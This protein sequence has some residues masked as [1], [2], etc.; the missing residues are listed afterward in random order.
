ME[1]TLKLSDYELRAIEKMTEDLTNDQR[2][3]I[4]VYI[5]HLIE[6][7]FERGMEECETVKR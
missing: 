5:E 3:D 6:L 7:A 2:T 1:I 4:V